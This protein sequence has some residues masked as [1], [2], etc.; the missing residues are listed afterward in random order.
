[1]VS[2]LIKSGAD[3]NSQDNDG[4]TALMWAARTGRVNMVSSLIKSG[5]DIHIK[6]IDGKTALL[7]RTEM[8]GNHHHHHVQ[9][10]VSTLKDGSR[11]VIYVDDEDN[12]DV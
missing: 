9:V 3:I 5:A 2:S 8:N 4:R 1:M 10:L 11:Y 12:G 6:D 7:C